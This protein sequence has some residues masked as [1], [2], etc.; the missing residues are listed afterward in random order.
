MRFA[1]V[2]L[3]ALVISACPGAEPDCTRD[4][5]CAA[6]FVCSDDRCVIDDIGEGE[7]EGELG[8][9]EGE[10]GEGE[11]EQACDAN[12]Q[13]C[14]N[15]RVCVGGFCDKEN[16]G[17]GIPPFDDLLGCCVRI[18]CLSNS[19][20]S[21]P[22][23]L[24]DIE[25]GICTAP[26]ACDPDLQIGEQGCLDNEVCTVDEGA[27][28]A[29]VAACASPPIASSCRVWPPRFTV[30][31]DPQRPVR[32]EVT[33][34]DDLGRALP[35]IDANVLWSA[36][37]GTVEPFGIWTAPSCTPVGGASCD[38]VV[39]ADVNGAS[40][41]ANVR[42]LD[43]LGAGVTRAV[44]VD[45]ASGAALVGVSVVAAKDGA[46][47][48]GT[49]DANGIAVLAVNAPAALSAFPEDDHAWLT[50]LAPP[51]DALLALDVDLVGAAAGAKGVVDFSR[52]S[53]LG[54]IS[55]AFVGTALADLTSFARGRFFGFTSLVN[56]ELEGITDPGGQLVPMSSGTL[57]F[58][59]DNPIKGDFVALG[60][61][62]IGAVWALGRRSPL[63]EV[64][65][66]ISSIATGAGDF[67]AS[68]LRFSL[69]TDA[70]VVTG[71]D[72]IATEA[73]EVSP[74]GMA[75]PLDAWDLPAV[76][77]APSVF[78]HTSADVDEMELAGFPGAL[79]VAAGVLPGAGLLPLGAVIVVDDPE[80][81]GNVDGRTDAFTLRTAPLHAGLEGSAQKKIIAAAFDTT[82][83]TSSIERAV[84]VV[85]AD[86]DAGL[87][88][89][90]PLPTGTFAPGSSFVHDDAGGGGALDPERFFRVIFDDGAGR[91]WSVWFPAAGTT[92]DIADLHLDSA[93]AGTRSNG[94]RIES[95]AV[96]GGFVAPSTYAEMFALD[97]PGGRVRFLDAVARTASLLCSGAGACAP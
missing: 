83:T 92:V 94:A 7:G 29:G 20:C 90:L 6:G 70:I 77:P 23:E 75:P 24:C 53:T 33:A 40:C 28:E 96:G 73:P 32:F 84:T 66:I 41:D 13:I 19:D 48:T 27:D 5:D 42:V 50:V 3:I 37:G 11:G 97:G 78:V 49:T 61:P 63:A 44:V 43:A 39:T 38:F 65:P 45:R 36:D 89:F 15:D 52:V 55:L 34:L 9:G 26:L 46:F 18:L 51:A 81:I 47:T 58:L 2:F 57:M 69:P 17:D 68:F 62:G 16:D 1:I 22:G 91:T 88:A 86:V 71:L 54:D 93:E 56:V 21:E 74:E 25:L 59:G 85:R 12:S 64:G 35:H 76:A 8:E 87:P 79:V 80:D 82:G 10:I 14:D 31:E 4:I 72:F 67:G 30:V 60:E 95:F